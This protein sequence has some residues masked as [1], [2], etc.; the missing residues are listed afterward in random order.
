MRKSFFLRPRVSLPTIEHCHTVPSAARATPA[1]ISLSRRPSSR[2]QFHQYL[3]H[4]AAFATHVA[5]S[6]SRHW[7]GL[8][9]LR[10]PLGPCDPCEPSYPLTSPQSCT[11]SSISFTSRFLRSLCP[12]APS[13]ISPHW[14][15]G[16]DRNDCT[17]LLLASTQAPALAMTSVTASILSTSPSSRF[18]RQC[19][20][21]SR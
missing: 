9:S 2:E 20:P 4:L 13:P 5:P 1:T 19:C 11:Q 17:A 16:Y 18:H 15:G 8:R 10:P 3:V 7:Y 6:M 14:Y 12:A 21:S